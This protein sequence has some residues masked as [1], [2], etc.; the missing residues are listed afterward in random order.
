MK[1]RLVFLDDEE[2]YK[3]YN[4]SK[5][6]SD[7][8]SVIVLTKGIVTK[9][10]YKK[11]KLKHYSDFVE[12]YKTPNNFDTIYWLQKWAEKKL[13]G[14]KS[15]KEIMKYDKYTLWYFMEY[16]L[17]YEVGTVYAFEE[18][19][20][21]VARLTYTIDVIESAFSKYKPKQVVV[22]NNKDIFYRVVADYCKLKGVECRVIGDSKKIGLFDKAK[23]NNYVIKNYLKTRIAIRKIISLFLE[24]QEST[25]IVMFCNERFC[26]NSKKANSLYGSMLEGIDSPNKII[27]YDQIHKNRSLINTIKHIRKNGSQYIGNYYNS[28]VSKK[29]KEIVKLMKTKWRYLKKNKDFKNSLNYK[30][31]D[32]YP[33]LKPRFDFVFNSFS[34]Y[35]ADVISLTDQIMKKEN[36]KIAVIEHDENFFGKAAILNKNKKTKILSLQTEILYPKGCLARH[37]KSKKALAKGVNWRPVSDVKFVS[38]EYGK[39]ILTNICN[40]PKKIIKIIGNPAYDKIAKNLK[41]VKVKDKKFFGVKK[42]EKLI[43]F[44]SGGVLQ[45]SE[46]IPEMIKAVDKIGNAKLII[47]AHPSANISLLNKVVD[48]VKSKNV[49]VMVDVNLYELFTASDLVISVCSAAVIEAM[50]LKKPVMLINVVKCYMPFVEM[51]GAYAVYQT[52]DIKKGITRGL[53]DEKLKKKLSSGRK[54]FL[55]QYLYKLDGKSSERAVSEI[56]R[57]AK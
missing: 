4:P 25:D 47:K 31:I 28:E 55:K 27:E 13:I 34:V 10:Y 35:I 8:N 22:Q 51:N 53:T 19:K 45:D 57:F 52:E 12:K 37:V 33:Y 18:Q 56:M 3:K 24:D 44:A 1:N 2:K 30:K 6:K 50:V 32:L 43:T 42:E 41:N 15:I 29:S 49:K 36:P 54:N 9:K 23:A 11:K 7:F 20:P 21:S 39:K 38:G 48:S 46:I 5:S 40:Y 26:K 14:K 17:F 16:F